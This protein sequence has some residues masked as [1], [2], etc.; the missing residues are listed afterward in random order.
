M[1]SKA[2]LKTLPNEPTHES[3]KSS[4]KNVSKDVLSCASP[5]FALND[6]LTYNDALSKENSHSNNSLLKKQEGTS[7]N[8]KLEMEFMMLKK[9]YDVCSKNL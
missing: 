9:K 8:S 4:M 7:K 3:N 1:N 6:K 5:T 2:K